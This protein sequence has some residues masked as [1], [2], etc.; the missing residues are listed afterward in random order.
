MANQYKEAGV[1][2][3][4]GEKAVDSI[5]NMVASTYDQSVIDG[6]G[7]F[8]A[9]YSLQSHFAKYDDP[10]LSSGTDGVGTKLMLAIQAK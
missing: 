5:K 1:D 6:L 10:V 3:E 9:M 7:G 8:G 2:V 4:S